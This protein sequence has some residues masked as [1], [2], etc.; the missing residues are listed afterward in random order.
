MISPFYIIIAILAVISPINAYNR[1]IILKDIPI[2][3][4]I[5]IICSGILLIYILS[6]VIR[7]KSLIP[8]NIKSETAKYLIINTFLAAAVLFLSGYILK[9]YDV[10]RFKSLQKPIYLFFL[11]II[12]CLIYKRKCNFQVVM[13]IGLLIGGCIL[14]DRNLK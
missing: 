2:E 13:G 4:E 9:H 5:L 10:L 1:E 8:N 12:A 14:V 6:Q 3:N 11:V 7:R